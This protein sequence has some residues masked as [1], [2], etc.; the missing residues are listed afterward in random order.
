MS[1]VSIILILIQ[2]LEDFFKDK[3]N[4]VLTIRSISIA[5]WKKNNL[6]YYLDPHSRDEKGVATGYGTSCSLRLLQLEDLATAIETNLDPSSEDVF[7]ISKVTVILYEGADEGAVKPSL[8]HYKAINDT[9]SILRGWLSDQNVKYESR[10]G[11]QTVPMC[12]T[13]VGFN[14]LKPASDW[15]PNDVDIILDKGL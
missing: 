3:D 4:G 1:N 5:I 14:R 10:R 6:Y 11:R 13:A 8:N 2:G 15:T 9:T 12:I 7:N